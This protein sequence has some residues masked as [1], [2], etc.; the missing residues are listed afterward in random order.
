MYE[1]LRQKFSTAVEVLKFMYGKYP[2]SAI[3]RDALSVG[4]TIAQLYSVTVAGKFLDATAEIF[5]N[6]TTFTWSEY[7]LTDSF[8]YLALTLTLWMIA[9]IGTQLREYFYTRI[10]EQS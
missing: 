9:Q 7:F 5:S 10:Y 1:K 2:I 6:W 8:Y 3:S 4:V